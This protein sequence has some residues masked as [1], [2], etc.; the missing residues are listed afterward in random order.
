MTE[1]HSVLVVEDYQLL[2]MTLRDM[3]EDEGYTAMHAQDGAS[4]EALLSEQSFSI[5]LLD[6]KLPEGDCSNYITQWREQYPAMPIIVMTA[7]GDINTAVDCMK[8][9]AED[10]LTK[11]VDQTLLKKRISD[12]LEREE[13]CRENRCYRELNKRGR[14]VELNEGVVGRSSQLTSV[15]QL[16][17]QIAENNFSCVLV[18]GETG[19]GK[20]LLAKKIHEAGQRRDKPFIE[21]NCSAIPATLAESELFGHKKGAFTDAK[22]DKTG[23]VELAN[24]GILFL[25]EIGDMDANLQTKLLK[26]IEEQVVRPIGGTKDIKVNVSIVAATHKNI[27]EMVQE[28]TFREDLYYRLNVIP[29]HIPPLRERP[30][31]I[32]DLCYYFLEDFSSNFQKDI[33]GFTDDAMEQ[34]KSY[35]WPGNTREI[36]NV[37]ERTC[38]L[39]SG[40]LISAD[41]PFL[42]KPSSPPSSEAD[43]GDLADESTGNPATSAEDIL[44][45]S[46]ISSE[47]GQTEQYDVPTL[48]QAEKMAVEKAIQSSNGNKNKAA[49]LLGVHRT[50]L[51]KKLTEYNID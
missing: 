15:V 34:L 28:G 2:G 48:A 1:R 35:Y 36:R 12:T 10:F 14:Y 18:R 23:L 11:P 39:C 41:N 27:E 4:A 9:G 5:A 6:F 32:E 47:E 51:Y 22:E 26:V 21:L 38:L 8:R 16:C 50:T 7:Y 25:D 33:Q 40:P 20:G 43:S 13:L 3:L 19:T 37:M 42:P 29:I 17:T 44:S 31:D 49:R 46:E 24:G 30:D 45:T